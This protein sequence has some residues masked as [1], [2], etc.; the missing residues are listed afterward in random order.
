ML[1]THPREGSN[2]F[3]RSIPHAQPACRRLGVRL[4]QGFC[5]SCT[6]SAALGL[7]DSAGF[8]DFVQ[9][10]ANPRASDASDGRPS[11]FAEDARRVIES[12]EKTRARRSDEVQFS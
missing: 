7:E 6:A 9:E 5:L 3:S 4:G 11:S 8:A 2:P 10:R 12:D 1:E